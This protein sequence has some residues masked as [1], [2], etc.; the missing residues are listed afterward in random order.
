MIL[1]YTL[2]GV[3]LLALIYIGIKDHNTEDK[4]GF[5]IADRKVGVLGTLAS[6]AAS[7]RDGS[8]LAVCVG[9]GFSLGYGY[10]NLF[11]GFLIGYFFLSMF[12]PKLRKIAKKHNYL[13]IGEF[14]RD[15]M[16]EKSEKAISSVIL[17]TSLL[18]VA[19]Q[20]YIL[21]NIVSVLL[22]IDAFNGILIAGAVVAFYVSSGGYQS[23]VRTDILQF[24]I[25]IGLLAF[26]CLTPLK[27][28]NVLDF[29]GAITGSNTLDFWAGILYTVILACSFPDTYQRMFSAKDDK[30]AK[31]GIRF[32]GVA[33]LLMS[34]PLTFIGMSARGFIP[35]DT[36]AGNVFIEIIKSGIYPKLLVSYFIV[37]GVSVTMSTLD[38]YAYLFSSAMLENFLKV[39]AKWHKKKYIYMSKIFMVSMLFVAAMLALFIQDIVQ[40][41]FNI[42]CLMLIMGPVFIFSALDKNKYKSKRLDIYYAISIIAS[43]VIGVYMF[44]QGYLNTFVEMLT[45]VALLIIFMFISYTI[46]RISRKRK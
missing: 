37:V 15:V 35:S 27:I 9:A 11:L 18:C 20:F 4:D 43:F 45:P 25:M 8:G 7:M 30:T 5:I 22:G 3:Y 32:I 17:A 6:S 36:E 26:V 29:S 19:M 14:V 13:T 44:V 12:A 23:I 24:F 2:L 1:T 10:Y 42:N 41:L 34:L 21:G 33:I 38:T 39:S 46:E 31:R 40:W 28:E 16:G